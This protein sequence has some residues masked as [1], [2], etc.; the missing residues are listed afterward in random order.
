MDFDL[1]GATF[2]SSFG[3]VLDT[4][5]DRLCPKYK[6]RY[7]QTGEGERGVPAA[8]AERSDGARGGAE[9]GQ[10]ALRQ[11]CSQDSGGTSSLQLARSSVGYFVSFVVL[12]L[13]R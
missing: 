8:V 11:L 10:G 2:P 12:K 3:T 6:P 13:G 9:G 7:L 5:R 1:E 4:L